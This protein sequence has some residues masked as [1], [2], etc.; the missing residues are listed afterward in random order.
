MIDESFLHIGCF[1]VLDC[2]LDIPQYTMALP[3][4]TLRLKS[5][6]SK[7]VSIFQSVFG[8]SIAK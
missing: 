8:I 5:F 3:F 6:K 1:L 7:L 4:R 2:L